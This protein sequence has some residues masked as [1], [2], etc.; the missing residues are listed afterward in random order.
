[1]TSNSPTRLAWHHLFGTGDRHCPVC[2]SIHLA[3][4]HRLTE[5][6]LEDMF[7]C[8]ACDGALYSHLTCPLCKEES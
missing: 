2:G 5:H 8:F 3:L 4:G 1:M 7:F 6:G